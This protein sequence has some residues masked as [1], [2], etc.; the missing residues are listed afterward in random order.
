MIEQHS[1]VWT[2]QILFIVL[3]VFIYLGCF[4]PLG[5]EDIAVLLNL[6]Y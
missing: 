5:M 4:Q 6:V 1:S 3:L 2:Y